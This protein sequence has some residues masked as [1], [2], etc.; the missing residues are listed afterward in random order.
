MIG[1]VAQ[2]FGGSQ[3]T[4]CALENGMIPFTPVRGFMRSRVCTAPPKISSSQRKQG[5]P[6]H[7]GF[8]TSGTVCGPKRCTKTPPRGRPRGHG[9]VKLRGP[10]RDASAQCRGPATPVTMG[11]LMG[12]CKCATPIRAKGH[13]DLRGVPPVRVG[14]QAPHRPQGLV[15]LESEDARHPGGR[16]SGHWASWRSL[17]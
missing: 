3:R 6:Y 1:N 7:Q 11:V 5:T 2:T 15:G 13:G 16:P 8:G 12:V 4:V 9:D 17:S 14:P 10:T